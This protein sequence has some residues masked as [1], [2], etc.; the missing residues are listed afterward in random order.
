[1]IINTVV[2]FYVSKTLGVALGVT[3]VVYLCRPRRNDDG[4]EGICVRVQKIS[5]CSEKV[6]GSGV[7][8]GVF[9]QLI[10]FSPQ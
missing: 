2:Y 7:E 4:K 1:M 9:H 3:I 5:V 6:E 10:S 8:A